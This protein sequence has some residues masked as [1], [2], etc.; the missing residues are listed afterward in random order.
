M[1][2]KQISLGVLA[3]MMVGTALPLDQNS[4]KRGI[5]NKGKHLIQC[6]KGNEPCTKTDF[7]ILAVSLLVVRSSFY[8]AI[9]VGKHYYAPS[10]HPGAEKGPD[11]IDREN[12]IGSSSKVIAKLL[13]FGPGKLPKRMV[14]KARRWW[15][16]TP[17]NNGSKDQKR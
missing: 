6:L 17:N 14:R 12:I 9:S 5:K 13:K 7:A 11:K 8:A 15:A 1:N 16:K 3:S 10:A 2:T 4:V